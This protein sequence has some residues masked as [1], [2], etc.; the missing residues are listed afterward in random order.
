MA[1]EGLTAIVTGAGSGIGEATACILAEAGAAVLLADLDGGRAESIAA[2]IDP[3][4]ARA[5]ACS[6]DI[7]DWQQVQAMVARALDHFGRVDVLVNSAGACTAYAGV[8]D[9]AVEDWD[10]IVD[11]NLR[12]TF[13]CCKAAIPALRKRGGSIVNVASSAALYW[14]AKYPAYTAAKMGVLGLTQCLARELACDGISVKAVRPVYVDTPMGRGAFVEQEGREPTE[15]DAG[16]MLRVDEV[17]RIIRALA[18]P[19]TACASSTIVDT[20]VVR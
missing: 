7:R 3:T 6:T 2:A 19:D 18:D 4:G 5:L 11:V 17:A 14:P 9:L 12:G 16:W 20:L 10:F 13:L 15:A 1:L 8:A